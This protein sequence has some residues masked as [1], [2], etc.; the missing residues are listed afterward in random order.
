MAVPH[1]A[2][3]SGRAPGGPATE[4]E[5]TATRILAAATRA[6]AED[7]KASMSD[8]AIASGVGRATLYRHFA[9]RDELLGAIRL[10]ALRE[11][12]TALGEVLPA[13]GPLEDGLGRVVSALLGVLDRYRVLAS[14]APADRS[15]PDQ[16]RLVEQVEGPIVALLRRGEEA[17]ELAP[18]V[19]PETVVVMLG[20]LLHAVRRAIS[21]GV[22]PADE[23]GAL[24]TRTLLRGVLRDG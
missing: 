14:T 22:L 13:D 20:G 18:D 10:Q 11:C 5:D 8:V 7:P 24:V 17:G 4:P 15:D 12:R 1:R 9:S 21:D 23:A 2:P 16:R 6:L 3:T 19:A